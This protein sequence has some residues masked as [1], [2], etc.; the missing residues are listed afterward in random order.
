VGF[1]WD[2]NVNSATNDPTSAYS[3][4]GLP[5]PNL[6]E[7]AGDVSTTIMQLAG[8]LNFSIPATDNI[9]YIGNLAFNKTLNHR[10]KEFEIGSV[11]LN[12][13]IQYQYGK[14]TLSFTL[15][16]NHFYV[17]EDAFREAYGATAQWQHTLSPKAQFSVY[18][19]YTKL[20][21]DDFDDRD[22]DRYVL[23]FNAVR[24]IQMQYN[25][26]IFGGLYVAQEDAGIDFWDQHIYG[27]RFGGQLTFTPRWVAYGTLGYERREYQDISVFS[28]VDRVDNQY[29][30]S[31]G[32]NFMPAPL[33]TIKPKISYIKNDS[34]ELL[35]EYDRSIFTVNVQRDFNW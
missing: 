15:Q 9:R 21:F 25:P 34:N 14:E 33:W 10:F 6:D 7:A 30:A 29:D 22:A 19:Q 3:I 8:G 32:L 11:D 31:I 28:Q 13:G 18:G 26:I 5:P 27:T 4:P 23:G 12:A 20:D 24:A 35:Y 1:G 16:N 17:E 2:S